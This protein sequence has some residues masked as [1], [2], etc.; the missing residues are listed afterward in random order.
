MNLNSHQGC[1]ILQVEGMGV[2]GPAD[3]GRE[4]VTLV[5]GVPQLAPM[6]MTVVDCDLNYQGPAQQ[7]TLS[8]FQTD[9]LSVQVGNLPYLT[10]RLL[11]LLNVY[12]LLF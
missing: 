1:E 5:K 12:P 6:L 2:L 9:F 3:K 10:I 4:E 7:V 11:L 8:T